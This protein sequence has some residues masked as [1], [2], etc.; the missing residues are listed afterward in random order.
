[1]VDKYGLHDYD[2]DDAEKGD[3][4]QETSDDGEQNSWL[5]E[6]KQAFSH[7]VHAELHLAVLVNRRRDGN[8]WNLLLR[9]QQ[10]RSVHF[11]RDEGQCRQR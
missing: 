9:K 1:M 4:D 11:T 3:D 6:L 2:E 5:S 7:R 10:G 8:G